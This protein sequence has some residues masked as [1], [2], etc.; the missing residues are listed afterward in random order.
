MDIIKVLEQMDVGF[1]A[2]PEINVHKH[3]KN[4]TTVQLTKTFRGIRF[5]Q[6]FQ[7]IDKIINHRFE[8]QMVREL[9]KAVLLLQRNIDSHYREYQKGKSLS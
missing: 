5:G 6:Q 3:D 4:V 9:E 8:D 7:L 1:G 2:D